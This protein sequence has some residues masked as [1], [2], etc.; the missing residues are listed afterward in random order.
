MSIKWYDIREYRNRWKTFNIII[1]ARG[2]GKTYSALLHLLEES[3]KGHEILYLRN[4]DVQIQSCATDFGNPFKAINRKEGRSIFI[5]RAK[6]CGYIYE[7]LGDDNRFIGYAAALSTFEN[8][9][10][11]NL[12]AVTDIVFDEF[13]ENRNLKFDQFRSF[14]SMYETINRNREIEG[15]EPL[16]VFMLS[17]AQKLYSPILAG[18]SLIPVV[19]EMLRNGQRNYSTKDIWISLP[20]SEVS[21]AKK[22]TALYRAAAGTEYFSEA[23]EN[24]FANDSFDAIR[25]QKIVEYN[26][27]CA[28]DDIYIYKHK[29]TGDFYATSVPAQNVQHYSSRV[30]ALLLFRSV[31]PSLALAYAGGSLSFSDFTTKARLLDLIG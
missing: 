11:V 17:N 3:A 21:E 19:E 1:S 8:L 2:V 13:I 26:P 6:E 16:R 5:K 31:Y 9:R 25:K 30:N 29:S 4:T 7:D 20:E 27:Y 18:F 14:L 24:K 22:D 12:E 28:I 23:I 10:G 15:Q